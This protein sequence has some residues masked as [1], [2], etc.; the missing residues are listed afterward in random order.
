MKLHYANVFVLLIFSLTCCILAMICN[1]ENCGDNKDRSEAFDGSGA[2]IGFNLF[3]MI[4]VGLYAFGKLER[5]FGFWYFLAI[6]ITIISASFALQCLTS[7]DKI[8]DNLKTAIQG[9]AGFTVPW[10]VIAG[11]VGLY[12]YTTQEANVDGS[13][14]SSK[15]RAGLSDFKGF[16]IPDKIV[17]KIKEKIRRGD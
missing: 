4:I 12:Y 3:W 5:F 1:K 15:L 6:L 9:V 11:G 16:I 7:C 2:M 13:G 14:F 10:A 8:S 17:Q